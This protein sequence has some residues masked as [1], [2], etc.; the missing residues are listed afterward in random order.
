M[1]FAKSERTKKRII[2]T[3]AP[4]FNKKGYQSTALS[5]I[6]SATGLTKG[7]IYGNFGNKEN[8]AEACFN[9]NV[10]FLQKGLQMTWAAHPSSIAKLIGL[11]NFYHQNYKTVANNGGCPLMN[12]AVEADDFYPFF[13]E[14]AKTILLTWQS[15]I[16]SVIKE[17]Q[18]SG[19][20]KPEIDPL[21]FANFYIASIEGGILI[22]KTTNDPESFFS[23][24][25]NLKSLVNHQ[26]KIT[27]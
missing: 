13:K 19:E 4:I 20:I 24:I 2:E 11:L 6:T 23:I 8:L 7:A 9:H 27:T 17:G 12:V 22:A 5:D 26:L 21:G 14:K 1:P 25:E 18:N 3:V 16:A 10:K 15:E